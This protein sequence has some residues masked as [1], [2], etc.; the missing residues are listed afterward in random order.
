MQFIRKRIANVITEDMVQNGSIN[1]VTIGLETSQNI[2]RKLRGDTNES[3]EMACVNAYSQ[4]AATHVELT[5]MG[6]KFVFLCDKAIR[7]EIFNTIADFN[8]KINIITYEELH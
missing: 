6:Q 4:I 3:I 5:D 8:I 7:Q 2:L 1:T